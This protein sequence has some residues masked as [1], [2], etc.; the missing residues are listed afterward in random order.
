VTLRGNNQASVSFRQN[1]RS[2]RLKSS[3]N[4]TL[5]LVRADGRWQIQE[6]KAGK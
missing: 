2:D 1:Y 3:S 6:E 5:E 4:K